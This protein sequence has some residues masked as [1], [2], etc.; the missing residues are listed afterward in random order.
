VLLGL[1]V[2][3]WRISEARIWVDLGGAMKVTYQG[4][5]MSTYELA[6]ISG[7]GRTTIE[8]RLNKGATVEQAIRRPMS[9]SAAGRLGGIAGGRIVFG[10]EA[11]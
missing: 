8:A 11:R 7:I 3:G 10:R 5:E 9:M 6:R 1:L 4:R 2:C